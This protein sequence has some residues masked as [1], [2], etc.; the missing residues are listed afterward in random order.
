MKPQVTNGRLNIIN[1]GNIYKNDLVSI[2]NSPGV[3]AMREGFKKGY[4]CEELCRHCKF[5]D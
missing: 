1:L 2:F 4:K 5:L 3:K